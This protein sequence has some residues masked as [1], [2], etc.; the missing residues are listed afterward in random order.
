[1]VLGLSTF[2]YPVKSFL[3]KV[4]AHQVRMLHYRKQP[5]HLQGHLHMNMGLQFHLG[6]PNLH[7]G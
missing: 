1:M 3:K 7:A 6:I 5:E 2:D 4:Q